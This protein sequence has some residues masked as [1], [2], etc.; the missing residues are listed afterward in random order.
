M[1]YE[2][3]YP[4]KEL[5]VI[6]RELKK[7]SLRFLLYNNWI[8]KLEKNCFIG[9][10][11]VRKL[12]ESKN[13]ITDNIRH[14]KISVKSYKFIGKKTR[15]QPFGDEYD[16]DNPIEELLSIRDLTHQFVHSQLFFGWK[17]GS[18]LKYILVA[19]DKKIYEKI[20]QIDIDDVIKIFKIFSEN[21][22]VKITT[23]YNEKSGN[24]DVQCS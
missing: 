16:Y 9:F 7:F 5:E 13:K 18:G 2:S 12:L 1:F 17:E 11:F 20:Y 19:S 22:V 10:Y 6:S 3:Y 24:F 4:K 21:N 14:Y 15:W 8:Y 23:T